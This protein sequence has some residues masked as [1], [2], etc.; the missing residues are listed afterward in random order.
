[1]RI[2]DWS[3]DVCS[4]DLT[5]AGGAFLNALMARV[6]LRCCGAQY[7]RI[8]SPNGFDF[9]VK[10][11]FQREWRSQRSSGEL[12]R[13]AITDD[14][15]QEQYL[16]PEFVIARQMLQKHDFEVEIVDGTGFRRDRGQ[17]LANDRPVDLIYN[18]MRSAEHTSTRLNSSH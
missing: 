17:L 7:A 13:I 9:A 4:S 2:S 15:P 11:M 12:R 3:S 8:S 14:S 18:R 10:D 1:M 16:Y 6:Q 5:N